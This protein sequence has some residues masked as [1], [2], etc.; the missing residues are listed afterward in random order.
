[1][2]LPKAVQS[3]RHDV[4]HQV[5]LR[6]DRIKH[7]GH[8][9]RLVGFVHLGETEVCRRWFS[10]EDRSPNGLAWQPWVST[11]DRG[12]RLLLSVASDIHPTSGSD[13]HP[14]HTGTPM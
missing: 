2:R 12:S 4:V 9:A 8:A 5:V 6:C 13:W 14:T 3:G 10:H 1:K 11:P 7:A